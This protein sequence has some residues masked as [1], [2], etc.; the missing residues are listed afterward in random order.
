MK[1]TN[2]G[3]TL[4]LGILPSVL[5]LFLW[6]NTAK[7]ADP[8]HLFWALDIAANVT[9]EHNSYA[10]NPSY[11]SWPGVNG[12][13]Q[14]ENRTK[15]TS[16]ITQILMQS[17]GWTAA[18]FSNWLGSTSP[19]SSRYYSA[20]KRQNGFVIIG[21]V[22]DIQPG[23]II[24]IMYPAGSTVTGHM[25]MAKSPAIIR[26]SS[27]PIIAGTDQYELEIIDSSQ[28]GHGPT[29]TRLRG[30]GTYTPGAGIGVFRLYADEN[31]GMLVGYTWSTYSVSQ[32]YDFRTRPMIIGRLFAFNS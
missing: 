12:V 6:T 18:D 27:S 4:L 13:W 5:C 11:I 7:A 25:M 20:I 3:F 17:Y 14:Y 2:A 19:S 28:S 29:D 1:K 9:P 15:C 10:S 21:N 24:A 23:D 31:T 22:N 32:F 30:D 26:T 16:F 8:A